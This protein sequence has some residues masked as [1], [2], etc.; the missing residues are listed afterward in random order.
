MRRR[1][2]ALGWLETPQLCE[3]RQYSEEVPQ[4]Y[5]LPLAVLFEDGRG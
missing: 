2:L 3:T 4:S 1:K 5:V